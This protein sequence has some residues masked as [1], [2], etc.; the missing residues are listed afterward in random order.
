MYTHSLVQDSHILVPIETYLVC[1]HMFRN[2]EEWWACATL[3]MR[4]AQHQH[5]VI[6]KLFSTSVI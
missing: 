3:P 4:A 1:F 6:W 2:A 5:L